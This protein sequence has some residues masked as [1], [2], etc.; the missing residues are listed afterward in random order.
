MGFEERRLDVALET[1]ILRPSDAA[2]VFGVPA[3]FP[4]WEMHSFANNVRVI[5]DAGL[6]GGVHFCGPENPASAYDLLAEISESLL[7]GERLIVAPIGTKPN[8]IG[9]A[10]FVAS[11]SDIGLLYDHP[12]RS[13][14]R[15]SNVARWHLYKVDL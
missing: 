3:F 7:S 6:S 4:G 15:T 2:V 14:G 13:P 8:G 12:K 1:Q 5:Q 10:V 9:A 11:H